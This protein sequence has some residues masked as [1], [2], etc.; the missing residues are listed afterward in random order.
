[1]TNAARTMCCVLDARLARHL[2]AAAPCR[3]IPAFWEPMQ[4]HTAALARHM[5]AKTYLT[6]QFGDIVMG[7]WW[8]DSDQVA[9]PLR[10]GRVGTALKDAL[11]WSQVLRT[12]IYP[13]L[14]RA[15]L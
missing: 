2:L 7:N 15:L 12:P 3:A 9:G 14:W 6:G 11:A 10:A 4:C 1:M 5:G 8:D 13:I